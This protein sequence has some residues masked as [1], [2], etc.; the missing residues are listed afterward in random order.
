MVITNWPFRH[1]YTGTIRGR[2]IFLVNKQKAVKESIYNFFLWTIND[3]ITSLTYAMYKAKMYI[4]GQLVG[5]WI[6]WEFFAIILFCCKTSRNCCSTI[7]W[8]CLLTTTKPPSILPIISST[9]SSSSSSLL[10]FLLR[11]K[12]QIFF[13]NNNRRLLANSYLLPMKWK[14]NVPLKCFMMMVYFIIVRWF[15]AVKT[16]SLRSASQDVNQWSFT[17]LT[18]LFFL[19]DFVFFS[20]CAQHLTIVVQ[21]DALTCPFFFLFLFSFSAGNCTNG[22]MMMIQWNE[23]EKRAS[24]SILCNRFYLFFFVY[25]I[26]RRWRKRIDFLL[27]WELGALGYRMK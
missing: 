22:K 15:T 6:S 18:L 25:G 26:S 11:F 16:V 21:L 5:R 17:R 10:I 19:S 7:Y 24:N 13:T 3:V 9:S 4:I 27:N 14:F 20:L 23:W 1:R 8:W 12:Q 2:R